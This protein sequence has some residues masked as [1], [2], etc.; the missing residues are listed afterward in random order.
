[1][2][3]TTIVAIEALFATL[4]VA[5]S[6]ETKSAAI[7]LCAE[8]GDETGDVLND[9]MERC[10]GPVNL[11]NCL[12]DRSDEGEAYECTSDDIRAFIQDRMHEGRFAA[13]ATPDD[14]IITDD[15]VDA[16]VSDFV[17]WL[18]SESEE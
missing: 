1:M 11:L 3:K 4:N 12:W 6:E 8:L 10:Y 9:L 5:T 7:T 13:F 2:N 15:Q 16:L 18:A 14:V 17:T